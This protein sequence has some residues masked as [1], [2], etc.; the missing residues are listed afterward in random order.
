VMVVR[1]L[2]RMV[3]TLVMVMV[4]LLLPL[5]LVIMMLDADD[6]RWTIPPKRTSRHAASPKSSPSSANPPGSFHPAYFLF[7]SFTNSSSPR[8]FSTKP[9]TWIAGQPS[10][11]I[12]HGTGRDSTN[13]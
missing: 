6:T 10:C 13:A 3:V 12:V 9:A 1:M 4:L 2:V 11:G 8:L 7:V 5:L